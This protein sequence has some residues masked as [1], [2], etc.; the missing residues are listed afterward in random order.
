MTPALPKRNEPFRAGETAL[1]LVDMQRVRL[2]PGAD[3]AHPERGPDHYFYRQTASQTIPN[4]ERL[5]AAARA[6]GVEVIHT[7]V[8]SLT[9]DGRLVPAAAFRCNRRTRTSPAMSASIRRNEAG[10]PKSCSRRF[11]T[12]WPLISTTGRSRAERR[13]SRRSIPSRRSSS[14]LAGPGTPACFTT[15]QS[16]SAGQPL[17]A[18]APTSHSMSRRTSPT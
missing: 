2:E 10:V 17:P 15:R 3:P 13:G 7:I 18:C 16:S 14:V 6:N 8:Q 4:Q 11:M 1:L 12:A 9:E 5:L